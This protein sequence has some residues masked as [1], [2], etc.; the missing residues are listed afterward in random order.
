M[1]ERAENRPFHFLTKV[2]ARK[3]TDSFCSVWTSLNFRGGL[4]A[5]GVLDREA[6][7][8][9]FPIFEGLSSFLQPKYRAILMDERT[10]KRTKRRE[11]KRSFTARCLSQQLAK[12]FA[13]DTP[14]KCQ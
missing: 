6:G 4:N 5:A 7:A 3:T 2:P 12:K 8:N 9:S 10:N 11:E 13:S 14:A 1:A